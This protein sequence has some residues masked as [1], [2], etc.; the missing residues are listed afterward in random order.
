MALIFRSLLPA[1]VTLGLVLLIPAGPGSASDRD[2][3]RSSASVEDLIRRLGDDNYDVREEATRLLTELDEAVPA[4]TRAAKSSDPE[5]A[6]RAQAVLHI[7]SMQGRGTF[8]GWVKQARGGEIDLVT[9]H[10]IREAGRDKEPDCWQVIAELCVALDVHQYNAAGR[11]SLAKWD[12]VRIND[13][14]SFAAERDPAFLTSAN[15][16][17]V[18]QD[19]RGPIFAARARAIDLGV[20]AIYSLFLSSDRFRAVAGSHLVDSGVF[21]NGS[22]DVDNVARSIFVC[23]G[24]CVVRNCATNCL[25]ITRGTFECR[26]NLVDC[27]V[28]AGGNVSVNPRNVRN[29]TIKPNEPKPLG[30]VKFF[31]VSRL[32]LTLDPSGAAVR[33]KEIKGDS[34]LSTAGLRPG[35]VLAAVDGKDVTSGESFRRAIRPFFATEGQTILR[36]RRDGRELSLPVNFRPRPAIMP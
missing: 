33:V 6:R 17:W 4:L 26:E 11:R 10:S 27:T 9:D 3:R 36:V 14:L 28:I 30:F 12:S 18:G 5:I 2:G 8:A 34:T 16:L 21:S 20:P 23:D 25:F 13:Y 35:D 15:A 19:G 7:L 31:D 32:G 1:A 24:D 22:I 29:T